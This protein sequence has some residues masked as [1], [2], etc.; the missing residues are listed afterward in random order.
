M[1]DVSQGPGWW[2]ASDGKWYPP[3]LHPNYRTP[4]PTEAQASSAHL[5]ALRKSRWR[6]RERPRRARYGAIAGVVVILAVTGIAVLGSRS[7]APEPRSSHHVARTSATTTPPSSWA[8]VTVPA[9][10]TNSS[11]Q[12]VSCPSTTFCVGVGSSGTA[13]YRRSSALV[14]LWNGGTWSVQPTPDPTGRQFASVS[15]VSTTSCVAVGSYYSTTT[16]SVPFSEVWNGRHW[17]VEGAPSRPEPN[18]YFGSSF[19]GVSCASAASCVAVGNSTTPTGTVTLAEVWNGTSWSLMTTPDS[20]AEKNNW[21]TSISCES[22][23]FCMAAGYDNNTVDTRGAPISMTWNGASW[24][25]DPVPSVGKN[26]ALY[27]VSCTSRTSCEAGGST[28]AARW[29]GASW[30]VQFPL[31]RRGPFQAVSC[32]SGLCQ[33]VGGYWAK[34]LKAPSGVVAEVWSGSRWA[35][36]AIALAGR[37]LP[38]LKGISC[39]SAAVCMAVGNYTKIAPKSEEYYGL[40]PYAPLALRYSR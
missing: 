20:S 36:E 15:C 27:S 25:L 16:R 14:E 34:A 5:T 10:T 22:S 21:L 23:R 33:A 26:S 37:R 38:T 35:K 24:S 9:V 7:H 6:K 39:V 2:I 4:A 17:V 1:S 40:G 32:V 29:N 28:F 13:K 8:S 30:T 12:D 11:L 3:H 31:T 18:S 19:Q